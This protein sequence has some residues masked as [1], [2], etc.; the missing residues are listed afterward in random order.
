MNR[1]ETAHLD[2]L[3]RNLGKHW[4][5]ICLQEPHITKFGNIRTP[6]QFRQVYPSARQQKDAGKVRSA[7]WIN[8]AIDTNTWERIDVPGTN[9]ITAANFKT[10]HGSIAIFNIYNPCDNNSVQTKLDQF[11]RA[12]RAKGYGTDDKHMLWC[13]DFNRHHPMWD[14]PEDTDLFTG[15]NGERAA[16]LI[17][18]LAEHDMV[19]TLPRDLPTICTH[20]S[21]RFTRPDNVFVS[22][23]LE[24][25][26]IN[27]DVDPSWRPPN[28]DHFPIVTTL[29]L[30]TKQAPAQ[31][32]KNFR[33]TDWKLFRST[34]EQKLDYATIKDEISTIEDLES[35]LEELTTILQQTINETVPEVKACPYMK[36]WWTK[37][38]EQAKKDLN[39][40]NRKVLKAK[41][42]PDH[43]IHSEMRTLKNRY[44]DAILGAKKKHWE[45]FLEEAAEKDMWTASK[46][47]TEPVGDGGNPRIPTLFTMDETGNRIEHNTNEEKAKVLSKTFFPDSPPQACCEQ[48]QYPEPHQTRNDITI[49]QVLAN[50]KRLAPFKAPGPDGIPNVV[51][52]KVADLIAPILANSFK[53]SLAL[54]HQY[55]GW[56]LFTTVVLRKPGKPSYEAPKAYRPIALLCT[57]AKLL[58]V[59]ITEEVSH[60]ME[61]HNDIPR[62]HYGGRPCRTTT[63]AVHH[64]TARIN[65]AWRRGKVTSVLY[66][67]VEGA[68][69]NAVT[70][71]LIHNLK[72]RRVAD[73]YV[74]YVR[75]LL[76]NRS[77]RLKFDD[78]LSDPTPIN[79]GIGQGDPLSMLLYIVYNSDLLDIPESL[80]EDAIGYVDDACLIATADD[81][82]TTCEMLTNMMER[83]RGGFEWSTEHSSRFALDK[84]AVTHFS[85][86]E[87]KNAR[88]PKARAKL[89]YPELKLRGQV[90]E[91]MKVYKYLGV[92]IDNKLKWDIQLEK[93]VAKATKW[94]LLFKRLARPALGIS[95]KL[96]RQLYLGVAIPK[97][98]Y[99]IDVWYEPPYLKEGAKKRTGSVK[100]LKKLTSLQRIAAIAITGG[101]RTTP[102]DI[103]DAHAGLLPC[104][105][106]LE[107]TCF[108]NA[109]RI[110]TLPA[111]N[112]TA[113]IAR[114]AKANR[115][116][117]H[118]P[119]L[120]KLLNTFNLEPDRIE[121]IRPPAF[122]SSDPLPATIIIDSTRE[123]SIANEARDREENGYNNHIRVYSDGSGQNGTIGAAAVLFKDGNDVPVKTLRYQLGSHAQYTTYDAEAVGAILATHLIK[124][125]TSLKGTLEE[126]IRVTHYVDSQ[127]V[128]M[129]LNKRR[130]GSGQHLIEA[131]RRDLGRASSSGTVKITVKWI[132]AHSGVAGNEI[133]DQAAKEAADGMS[134]QKKHLPAKLHAKLPLS[135]AA[136]KRTKKAE[137]EYRDAE[138]W[139]NSPRFVRMQGVDGDYP[140]K[141]FRK[142]RE[143]LTRAQGSALIQ[144]RSGHIPINAYL[145]RFKKRDND[146]CD[147]CLTN[148]NR[149]LPETVNHY[150]LDC[151]TYNT[152]RDELKRKL[153]RANA[154]DLERLFKTEKGTRELL[155]FLDAT[156][157]LKQA[158]GRLKI[159][160]DQTSLHEATKRKKNVTKAQNTQF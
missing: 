59:I 39:R 136:V 62:S 57:M 41:S 74:N 71:R 66:L 76:R 37:E 95:Q 42:N 52:Q 69:P 152:E 60:M 61:I 114:N 146:Y 90:V 102:N 127:G 87:R 58:T 113:K 134:S 53:A 128:I 31:S 121:K 132:S 109:L 1:S 12:N 51:L 126:P 82:K 65:E 40:A 21:K 30:P 83:A 5:V 149:I 20:R 117:R 93:T 101:L 85:R 27:C 124:Q 143:Y 140:Y 135:K 107:L 14:R 55:T 81:F 24:N 32:G 118:Q 47:L 25:L 91:A 147:N 94:V 139:V 22:G 33:M 56:K 108:R 100:A 67:D 159:T 119:N 19:M 141:K 70:E 13:G 148:T 115:A 98:T 72:K 123:D 110:C 11:L 64:L 92:H 120:C 45:D 48:R 28:T 154:V 6:K 73:V 142:W 96:M 130:G 112:P 17:E 89:E 35:G 116:K 68:F 50:I 160:Q 145:K 105:L 104:H 10:E 155:N 153:G 2:L 18:I 122:T 77:T 103:L 3:N 23:N 129:A 16:R 75:S 36:R 8:Q 106:Q 34:L 43:P 80:D 156:K 111:N 26:V 150:I 79:N 46:Y 88:T 84:L 78:Y 144:I 125:A 157:R 158:L 38:L 44:A 137:M 131:Y 29:E 86:T 54:G 9:D 4:D 63:D 7:M 133:V 49:D 138:S 151:P 97:M 15:Q 99:A